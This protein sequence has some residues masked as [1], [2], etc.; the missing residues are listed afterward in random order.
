M[1]GPDEAGGVGDSLSWGHGSSLL[2]TA[3]RELR[4]LCSSPCSALG[5]VRIL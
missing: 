2:S 1:P 5:S 3:G 4:S